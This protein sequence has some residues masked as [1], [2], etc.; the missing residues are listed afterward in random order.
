MIG[1]GPILSLMG[2]STQTQDHMYIPK[3]ET[4]DALLEK[5]LSDRNAALPRL[6][7]DH[8]PLVGLGEDRPCPVQEVTLSLLFFIWSGLEC[9]SSF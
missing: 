2:P 9:S 6:S 4:P 7:L 8:Q 5:A 1:C 3:I